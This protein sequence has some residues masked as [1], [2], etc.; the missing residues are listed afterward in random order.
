MSL[1]CVLC[2]VCSGWLCWWWLYW[3]TGTDS[4]SD[5]D[6]DTDSYALL[7][8]SLAASLE[9]C[10]CC[11]SLAVGCGVGCDGCGVGVEGVGGA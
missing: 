5:S 7:F 2:T 6:T 9:C 4:D 10:D 3:E 8:T 1:C 11:F